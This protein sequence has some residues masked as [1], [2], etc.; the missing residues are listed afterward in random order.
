MLVGPFDPRKT[1]LPE[2]RSF[3]EIH[4]RQAVAL[5]RVI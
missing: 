1:G 4:A 3:H 2:L 5:R